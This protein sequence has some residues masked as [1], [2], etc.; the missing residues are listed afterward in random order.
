LVVCIT[1]F[2]LAAVIAFYLTPLILAAG[3]AAPVAIKA[4]VAAMLALFA[5]SPAFAFAPPDDCKTCEQH[6]DACLDSPLSGVHDDYSG[7]RCLA[8]FDHCRRINGGI[9][10]VEIPSGFSDTGYKSC[11]Y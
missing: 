2:V 6:L 7:S 10:P 3:A 9:W 11:I 8:C 4:A 1:F 5:A